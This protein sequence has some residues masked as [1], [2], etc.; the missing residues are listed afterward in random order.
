VVELA[1]MKSMETRKDP[2]SRRQWKFRLARGL[3]ERGWKGEQVRQFFLFLAWRLDL[4]PTLEELFRQDVTQ[5][6][7]SNK[8]SKMTTY[9]KSIRAEILLHTIEALVK[10]RFPQTSETILPEIR[11]ILDY[12][13]LMEI[14]H[15]ALKAESLDEIRPLMESLTPYQKRQE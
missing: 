11:Q 5:Y 12:D 6:E 15:T 7:E 8:M 1:Q 13:V 3:Y 10:A 4:P 2:E 9:E 14:F